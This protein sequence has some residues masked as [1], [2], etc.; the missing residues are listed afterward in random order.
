MKAGI[1]SGPALA[2]TDEL[3][4]RVRNQPDMKGARLADE[5]TTD[6]G[7]VVEPLDQH[8]FTVAAIDLGIKAMTPQRLSERGLDVHVLPAGATIDQV[9]DLAPDGVFFSNGPGDPATADQPVA[10]LRQL[11][12]DGTPYFGIC[13]GMQM[14]VIE[15]LRNV[16][17]IKDASSSEF[18]STIVT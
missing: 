10:L 3:V 14:A 2:D 17:G 6:S 1:F 13:F 5:V 12:A 11:L 9:R 16:A 18:G 4:A 8:R 7:Y 15:T